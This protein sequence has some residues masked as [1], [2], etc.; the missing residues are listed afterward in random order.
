VRL[1]QFSFSDVSL[2]IGRYRLIAAA[3]AFKELN[4]LVELKQAQDTDPEKRS[5]LLLHM[6]MKEGR[7]RSFARL[8]SVKEY[9]NR[10]K[11]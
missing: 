9:Q 4:V 6:R 11:P 5:R 8:L 10:E 3:E 7:Q 2:P 1:N